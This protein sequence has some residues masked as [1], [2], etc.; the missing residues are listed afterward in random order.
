M[1]YYLFRDSCKSR[2]Y[3]HTTFSWILGQH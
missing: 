2:H 3:C 1:L